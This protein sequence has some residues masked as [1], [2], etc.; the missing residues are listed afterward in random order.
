MGTS[1][2]TGSWS[3]RPTTPGFKPTTGTSSTHL[4]IRRARQQENVSSP[5]R[6]HPVRKRIPRI[7]GSR[8]GFKPTTGTSSTLPDDQTDVDVEVF[9][10]HNGYI[11]YPVSTLTDAVSNNEFQ[12]HNGYIQ[13]CILHRGVRIVEQVSSPQRVHP[14]PIASASI[15][16]RYSAFQAHNGYIQYGR[17]GRASGGPRR[18]FKPTTGTSSTTD[19]PI[20]SRRSLWFQAH[21]GYIQYKSGPM[22]TMF[23]YHR[24]Q[25][26][27]GYIQYRHRRGRR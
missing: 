18:R 11:Q 13:Y 12:A 21:N 9:Q 20:P 24:F 2:T 19:R 25:A 6:V 3:R 7:T 26:H 27:N 5:Q 23:T 14:V 16:G 4:H 8:S 10:A 15:H 17:R 1:S 22:L